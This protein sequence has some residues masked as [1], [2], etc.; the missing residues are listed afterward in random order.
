MFTSLSEFHQC[1]PCLHLACT[2]LIGLYTHKVDL[3][4]T[5]TVVVLMYSR[6]SDWPFLTVPMSIVLVLTKVYQCTKWVL[7]FQK[8]CFTYQA[9][10]TDQVSSST[11]VYLWLFNVFTKLSDFCHVD[12]KWPFHLHPFYNGSPMEIYIPSMKCIHHV[13]FEWYVYN[14]KVS[15]IH[16][17]T[18]HHQ[19]VLP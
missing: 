2:L 9:G 14:T 10:S 4:T 7:Q 3:Q 1:S 17:H 15:H 18:S 6:F 5:F 13:L 16:T 12:L 8:S 19:T 11:N